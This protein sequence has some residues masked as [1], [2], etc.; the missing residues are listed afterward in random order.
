[1]ILGISAYYHDSAAALVNQKGV[2]AA[3]QEDRFTRLK[4]DASFPV[5]SVEYCLKEAGAT[6]E[7]IEQIV[8]YEKPFLKFD[9]LLETYLSYAPS[10]LRSFVQAVPQW[11]KQ[12][13]H[14]PERS[15]NNCL[16]NGKAIAFVS[17]HESHAASAFFPSP[18]E[19]SAILTMDGVGEWDT[20][21][22]GIGESNRFA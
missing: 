4:H 19:E 5:K 20:T 17:H 13:L 11:L 2:I 16:G 6:I 9:R 21:T 14:L 1:M 7:D 22:L 12:K 8:F 18:F 15:R 3:A 10:G